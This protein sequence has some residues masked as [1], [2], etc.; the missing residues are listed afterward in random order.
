MFK[1]SSNVIYVKLTDEDYE[2]VF[3]SVNDKKMTLKGWISQLI[4][5]S[6]EDKQEAKD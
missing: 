6:Q 4:K 1:S 3:K 5:E 2:Y